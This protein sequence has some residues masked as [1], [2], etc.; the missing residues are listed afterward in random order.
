[1]IVLISII[2]K[3]YL[4]IINI[5]YHL[6]IMLL[7][8]GRQI[9]CGGVSNLDSL[10]CSKQNREL[11]SILIL[12]KQEYEFFLE[13]FWCGI[14]RGFFALSKYREYKIMKLNISFDFFYS[15]YLIDRKEA[16]QTLLQCPVS[17]KDLRLLDESRMSVREIFDL[18]KR[19][20]LKR[21][22][23]LLNI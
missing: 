22:I 10:T 17:I 7:L 13:N 6:T 15:M 23:G 8:G 20:P 9:K 18:H 11:L 3:I 2:N 16:M 5:A 4:N 12:S 21:L 19:N 14:D 1:M